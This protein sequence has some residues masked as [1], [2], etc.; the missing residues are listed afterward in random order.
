MEKNSF[1]LAKVSQ[2]GA[3]LI[4]REALVDAIA[5]GGASLVWI[6][7]P[8]GS[9]KTSL[10]LAFARRTAGPVAWLRLDEAD[11]DP[12][13]FM[14]YFEQSVH[15]GRATVRE[16][17]KPQLL[18]EHLPTPQGYFRLF[19]RS[20]SAC[21][22][23]DA[24]LVFDD[25]H[26]CQDVRFFR[27]FLDILAEE[28]PPGVRVLILS[29]L[30]P[31][32]GCARLLA[33]GQMHEL[34]AK[35]LA[36]SP[37]ET[38]SLLAL[39]GIAQAESLCDTVCQYTDGWAAGI[40]LVANWLW[41]R[42]DGATRQEDVSR[43]VTG[44]LTTEVFSTFTVPERET[45][46][47]V[48]AL[49][50][51]RTDWAAT[52]SGFDDAE[53]ILARL[54]AQGGLIYRY[55]GPR[56]TLHPLFQR[57]LREWVATRLYAGRRQIWVERGVQLLQADGN[58]DAAIELALEYG[59]IDR[60]AQMIE[61]YAESMLAK[62]RHQTLA[63]WIKQVPED[64][65][66]PWLH[67]WLGMA[68]YASDTA[69]A[70]D[71][72]LKAYEEFSRTGNQQYR[73]IAL[74][75]VIISYSFNGVAKES[76][77]DMLARFLDAEREYALLADP[78]LRAHL[79]LGIYSGLSTTD[80]GHA[81]LPLWEE[82][83]FAAL[84]EPVSPGMKV[85]L[86]TWAA[87]HLFFSGQYRRISALRA[88][89][90]G[91]VDLGSVPAYQGYLVYFLYQFDEVVRGDMAMLA[92]TYDAC[93]KSSENTGFR[94]MDGHYA[95]QFAESRLLQNDLEGARA[96][97]ARIQA[98][99]PPGHYNL[100]GHFHVTQY[101]LALRGGDARTALHAAMRITEAGRG[102]GSVPYEMWGRIG[103]STAS[104]LLD[105]PDAPDL[106]AQL[107]VRGEQVRYPAALIHADLLDAWRLDRDGES[108]AA[109]PV[110]QRALARWD[111]QSEGFLW[112][113]APQILQP[114]CALALSEDVLPQVA[115]NII[116]AFRL[117]PPVDA[118]AA[119]PWPLTV[120]CFGAFELRV[121]GQPLPSRGKSKH[122]QL[123]LVKLVAA[124]APAPLP[125]SRIAET[126][127]PDSEGDAARHALDTTLSR[128]RSTLGRE[129]F[130]L[131][132]GALGLDREVCWLDTAFLEDALGKLEAAL[133]GGKADVLPETE[134][135][136]ELYRG[137]LLSG[138]TPAWLLARREF[139]RG[140]LSRA[141]GTAARNLAALGDLTAAARLL[142]RALA[143]DPYCE[144]LTAALMG[145][146]LDAG[147]YAEGMAAYRRYR[148]IA[149]ST[150]GAPVAAEIETLAQRLH[151]AAV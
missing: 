111:E 30:A 26:K 99:L 97:L 130:R 14:H 57:Y 72:L 147:R 54:S 11:T 71:A 120:R 87:I 105:L 18:G 151:A 12:A 74:S 46:L 80:P 73:F 68:G 59:F 141:F 137:D 118:P 20:L 9:G 28:M 37:A 34:D 119:W 21:I 98:A 53:T 35:A 145:V 51:F 31:P 102:F 61:A 70:R 122:R 40:A 149:L 135:V 19:V 47:A 84:N 48:C 96:V 10:A 93:Q 139:W 22:A 146:C 104:M 66:S 125:L 127:W 17:K 60:A 129:V 81:D 142:D 45:L 69:I 126:L 144:P 128:L 16:W 50:Y 124:H 131:E 38:Q 39:L 101:S 58:L 136:L 90:D 91:L 64:L 41:H 5:G 79:A 36:F 148:R 85:R 95:L 4:P 117:S 94:N 103:A 138:E 75:M 82:R 121:G 110:L 23:P 109:L 76:L 44:Y 88:M 27:L 49:P 52:L 6:A 63:R 32:D 86:A 83:C 43:L 78:E 100:A 114:L 132:H 89:L 24:C 15:A 1:I 42:P 7:A 62:T 133:A 33:H 3:T 115:R 92:T 55:P 25:A 150:L 134:D 123:E 2:P 8:A 108:A 140:R 116:R 143:A 107:R 67:Y 13:S 56:Y 112:A 77:K 29:R 65:R 113:A 106:V